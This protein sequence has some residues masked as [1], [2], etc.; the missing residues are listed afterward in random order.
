MARERTL[1]TGGTGSKAEIGNPLRVCSS[2]WNL[3]IRTN[4]PHR[5]QSMS[6][7][8]STTA[9]A[10]AVTMLFAAGNTRAGD[11]STTADEQALLKLE[12]EWVEAEARHDAVALHAILDDRFVSTFGAGKPSDK[13]AFIKEVTAGAIDPTESQEL[14]DHTIIV[15]GHTAVVV[16]TDT[17]RSTTNGQPSTNVYRFTVTY[18]KRGGH[19]F[20]L[21]E[22]GVAAKP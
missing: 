16:E 17:L 10:F 13:S 15:A 12:H 21:A 14:S 7:S 2:I 4:K 18:I 5:C 3:S 20:A 1:T 8:L 6:K 22:H 19:W 11:K 9:A